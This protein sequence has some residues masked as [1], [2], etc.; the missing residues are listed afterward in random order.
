MAVSTKVATRTIVTQPR[1][2]V[3]AACIRWAGA[4]SVVL[5]A[6]QSHAS[7]PARTAIV[8]PGAGY[9]MGWLGRLFLG[10][11]WRDLWT[12]P[13]EV[14]V[15]DLGS[16]DGGLT[17]DREGGGLETSSLHFKSGNGRHWAFRSVDKDL[18]RVLPPEARHS[19]IGALAQDFTSTE[20]PAGA[21][22]TA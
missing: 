10:W 18:T 7:E 11:E 20:N 4:I 13:I 3:R 16:F 9:S 2:R 14:P 1:L 22:I 19:L 6:C 12:T 17:P 8:E 15:L 21:V 5:L